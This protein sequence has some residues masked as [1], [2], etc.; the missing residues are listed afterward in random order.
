[1]SEDLYARER[2]FLIEST[3]PCVV[4]DE[5]LELRRE[6]KV[7]RAKV[8]SG[9]EAAHDI[10]KKYHDWERPKD[11]SWYDKDFECDRLS[12]MDDAANDILE[13][14]EEPTYY[15]TFMKEDIDN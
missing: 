11:L 12:L 7:L 13:A 14:M 1:M 6:V 10:Q 15:E 5:L 3:D 9:V 8:K 2:D 4:V